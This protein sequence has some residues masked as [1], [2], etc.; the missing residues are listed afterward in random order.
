MKKINRNNIN[1]SKN[2]IVHPLSKFVER[3]DGDKNIILM[4]KDNIND[5][6]YNNIYINAF[7]MKLVEILNSSFKRER[8]FILI[9]VCIHKVIIII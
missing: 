8:N 3:K 1:N 9:E 6:D 4:S 7:F 2:T 5:I